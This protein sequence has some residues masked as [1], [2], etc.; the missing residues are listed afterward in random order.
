MSQ[1]PKLMLENVYN[2]WM[3]TLRLRV[4]ALAPSCWNHT[5]VLIFVFQICVESIVWLKKIGP[6][7]F[8]SE[9]AHYTPTFF[10]CSDNCLNIISLVTPQIQK[11]CALM[12]P[13]KWNQA[14]SMK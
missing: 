6:T 10:G 12:N 5:Y 1:I 14:L 3:Y 2:S 13:S 7:I 9:V 8:D 4:Q 11:F